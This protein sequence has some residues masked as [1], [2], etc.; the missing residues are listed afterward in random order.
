MTAQAKLVAR[1][2]VQSAL[3]A[4]ADRD[5][6]NLNE[7]SPGEMGNGVVV[8]LEIIASCREIHPRRT[9]VLSL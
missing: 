1:L 9:T 5:G 2:T 4:M 6:V 3:T 7:S 8:S